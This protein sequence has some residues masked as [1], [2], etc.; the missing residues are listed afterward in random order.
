MLALGFALSLPALA[1]SGA[2]AVAYSASDYFRKAVPSGASPAL[3]LFFGAGLEMPVLTTWLVVSGDARLAPGYL[4]PGL[5]AAAVGLGASLLFII[6]VRRSPLSLMIPLLALV[7]ALTALLGGALLGEWPTARQTAGIF[8]VIAG[9]FTLFV[10]AD[11]GFH[12]LAV[13]RNLIRQPGALPMAGVVVL[14][15]ISPP[16]DKLCMAH[17]SV[18]VHG[19]LQLVGLWVAAGL[20]L[21]LRGGPKAFAPP[22]GAAIPLLGV[23]I[24]AGLAYAL[25]LAAYQATLVAVVELIKRTIGLLGALVFGRAYFQESIT[26]PK[27]WGVAIIVAGLPLVLLG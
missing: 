10:P 11:G 13:W 17:A 16:V 18:G 8:V 20:W 1:L 7:P 3:V 26:G 24:T 5:A 12:P 4:L 9:L 6:A 15:S 27:A 25:Q 23:G 22:P 21:V 19:L 14:W 2:C